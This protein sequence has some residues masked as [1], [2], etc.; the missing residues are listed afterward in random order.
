MMLPKIC[1]IVS[2]VL[3]ENNPEITDELC[4]KHPDYIKIVEGLSE[5]GPVSDS[6]HEL[7]SKYN[8]DWEII[9]AH[10]ELPRGFMQANL[11]KSWD[12]GWVTVTDESDSA[13]D[14]IEPV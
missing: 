4:L 13:S 7:L 9:T 1:D 2:R 12:D 6:L 5:P 10:P 8:I 14:T 11:N 3:R